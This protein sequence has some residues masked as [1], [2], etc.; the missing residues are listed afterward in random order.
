MGAYGWAG[1]VDYVAWKIG[2]GAANR[3]VLLAHG[4]NANTPLIDC[5]EVEARMASRTRH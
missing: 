4:P 2:D 1:V 3:R 5:D